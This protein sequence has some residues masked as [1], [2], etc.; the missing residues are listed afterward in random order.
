MGKLTAKQQAFVREYRISLN[1]TQAA[2]KAGYSENTAQQMGSENLSKP[3]IQV[4][5]AKSE[6]K[7]AEKAEVNA[8][9]VARFW[10]DTMRSKS[11]DLY[12]QDADGYMIPKS[13]EDMGPAARN[14]V[15]EVTQVTKENTQGEMITV[16][17]FKTHDRIKASE[18]LAKSL[19]MFKNEGEGVG[20][21]P[22]FV[23]IN[24][25]INSGGSK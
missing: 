19:G 23:G 13:F 17:T 3:V 4:E 7:L 21:R 2:I 5:L 22:I 24:L 16:Q 8:V 15:S 18:N 11:E 6:A 1:A 20:E 10:A 9:E 14:A 25:T 12:D